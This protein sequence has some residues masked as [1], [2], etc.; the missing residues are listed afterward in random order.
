MK[1]LLILFLTMVM[2]AMVFC[3]AIKDPFFRHLPE[4]T[5]CLSFCPQMFC[6]NSIPPCSGWGSMGEGNLGHS[7]P[8]TFRSTYFNCGR[9]W[10]FLCFILK[11]Q[12]LLN[13]SQVANCHTYGK[14]CNQN[15]LLLQY[16]NF[17]LLK[18]SAKFQDFFSNSSNQSLIP[19]ALE[20][21]LSNLKHLGKMI[22]FSTYLIF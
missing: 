15:T 14:I 4:K 22:A 3:L 17:L 5:I 7:Y 18:I 12:L 9:K 19:Y 8:E 16:S 1:A 11:A 13:S 10:Q 6:S 2:H 20:K 21:V